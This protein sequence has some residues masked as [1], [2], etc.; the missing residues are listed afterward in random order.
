VIA[1]IAQLDKDKVITEISNIRD[2]SGRKGGMRIE[3]EL[4]RDANAQSVLNKLY[5]HTA[6][7][8]TFGVNMVALV[9]NV[10]RTLGIRDVIRHY[11]AHQ[12]DVVTRR[13]KWQLEQAERRA[14]ILE[15]YLIALDN[16]DAVIDLIRSSPDADAARAG[17]QERFGLSEDQAQAILDL[18]LQRLTASSRTGSARSTPS[19][20][21]GSP[22]CGRSWPTRAAC[23]R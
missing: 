21:P 15:G 18:R 2:L 3:I 6:L 22:S 13:T 11:V 7:Q 14:H 5:R 23:W 8:S 20:R 17:L 10:P 1:K 4:K 19:S 9:D 16:L 12:Q